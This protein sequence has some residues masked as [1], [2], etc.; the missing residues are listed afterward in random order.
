MTVAKAFDMLSFE[1]QGRAPGGENRISRY[2][3]EAGDRS[4]V[5]GYR[6]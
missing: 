5:T 6:L 2:G 4:Q 1:K 3:L